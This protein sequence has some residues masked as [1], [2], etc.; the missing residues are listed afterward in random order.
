ML[1][2]C[3]DGR[4]EFLLLGYWRKPHRSRKLAYYLTP[5]YSYD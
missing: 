4:A 5:K 3:D 1:P 2:Y